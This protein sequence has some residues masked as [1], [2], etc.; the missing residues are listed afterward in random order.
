MQ[1][2]ND[3]KQGKRTF[4]QT[5]YRSSMTSKEGQVPARIVQC[6]VVNLN[7]TNYTVDVASLFDRHRYY[8]IQVTSPY[9]HFSNGE[10]LTCIP[11]VGSHCLVCLPSDSTQPFVLSFFM[12][13]QKID[14]ASAPDAPQGTASHG[15]QVPYPSAATFAGGRPT[16]KPGDMYMR[17]RDGNF[18]IL[19]RGGVLQIG[20]T[21]L[22]QRIFIPLDNRMIDISENYAHHNVG[23]SIVW[24]IQDGAGQTNFPT[25]QVE[26]FR[27]FAND[28]Y[29][30]VRVTRG[31]VPAPLEGAGGLSGDVVYEVAISPKGFNADSGD[32]AGSGTAKGIVYH[33]ATDRK[34]NVTMTVAGQVT[35]RFKKAVSLS[36]DDDLSINGKKN[37][38]IEAPDSLTIS[39]GKS[40][41]VKGDMV[42]LG[43]GEKAVARKGDP[44]LCSV[45]PPGVLA[46]IVFVTPPIP[47]PNVGAM[48]ILMQPL[49]GTISAGNDKVRA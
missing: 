43:A 28:K 21:E 32:A 7:L 36:F 9:Q 16:P 14:D 29:A 48:I 25:Q 13:F 12:P 2:I 35:G 26:T 24:G 1:S 39:G 4:E 11:E 31:K 8:N 23:G 27:I 49:A 22:S 37:I 45:G 34:G 44:V 42:R 15:A 6:R 17:G 10:G 30:D 18:F 20:A 47:G 33:F 46:T 41:H 19:H 38:F 5:S 40:T 3:N